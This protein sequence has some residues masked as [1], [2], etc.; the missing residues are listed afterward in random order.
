MKRGLRFFVIWFGFSPILFAAPAS[1]SAVA[2]R[3]AVERVYYEH[4]LGN[5][6][7]FEEALSAAAIEKMVRAE[8]KKEAALRRVYRVEIGDAEIAEELKRI[9]ASTRAPEVLAEI[10][11]ALGNDAARFARAVARPIIVERE[12][13]TRFEN[14][15]QVH[16]PFLMRR[17][18]QAR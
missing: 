1:S 3:A 2:D 7:P 15:D 5:K 18:A 4:R 11:Q 16:A 12:L 8:T 6:G 17:R 13:R 9:E 10:K 14:D